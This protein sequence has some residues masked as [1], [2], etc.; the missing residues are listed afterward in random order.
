MN[1]ARPG[2]IWTNSARMSWFVAVAVL[3]EWHRKRTRWSD[4]RSGTRNAFYITV[5]REDEFFL[6]LASTV[7]GTSD[8]VVALAVQDFKDVRDEATVRFKV[9]GVADRGLAFFLVVR[10]DAPQLP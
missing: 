8:A 6:S 5:R 4:A 7:P 10:S 9:C 2:E 1:T 3:R